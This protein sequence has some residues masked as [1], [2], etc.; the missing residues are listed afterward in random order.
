MKKNVN[1]D[2]TDYCTYPSAHPGRHHAHPGQVRP[3]GCPYVHPPF[4]LVPEVNPHVKG[5][6]SV[7][8]REGKGGGHGEHGW[9]EDRSRRHQRRQG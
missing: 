8:V 2:A 3:G 1:A 6:L 5:Y 4:Q 9:G 7:Y